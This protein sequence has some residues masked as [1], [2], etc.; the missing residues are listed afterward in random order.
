MMTNKQWFTI[1]I[2]SIVLLALVATGG[3]ALA[4]TNNIADILQSPAA[5]SEFDI[6]ADIMLTASESG[7]LELEYIHFNRIQ[8]KVNSKILDLILLA[9]NK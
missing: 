8:G 9:I 3:F 7:D 2:L 5:T 1:S 4:I 6:D